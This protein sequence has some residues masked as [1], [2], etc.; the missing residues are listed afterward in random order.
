MTRIFSMNRALCHFC[1]HADLIGPGEPPEDGEMSEMTL[2]SRHRIQTLEV[3]GW[4]HYLSATVAPHNTEFYEWMGKKHFCF[5]Q[6][7]KTGKGTQNSSV[8]GSGANHYP[9]ALAHMTRKYWLR[10]D[11][12]HHIILVMV[13][14]RPNLP[15]ALRVIGFY[16]LFIK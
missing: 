2:P 9:L 8:R 1:A 5:F 3:W 15:G 12:H 6:T 4:A 16:C 11:T 14:K 7:A 13:T 10:T